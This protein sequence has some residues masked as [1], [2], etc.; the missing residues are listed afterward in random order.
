VRD[1][2]ER[3]ARLIARALKP[4]GVELSPTASSR[5]TDDVLVAH[6]EGRSPKQAATLQ[7]RAWAGS[8]APASRATT[9]WVLQKAS[10]DRLNM[11]R[12]RND[13]FVD[14]QRGIVRLALPWMIVD[15]SD[16]EIPVRRASSERALRDPFGDRASLVT[17]LLVEQPERR[18]GAREL[19][20]AA[21]VSTMTASH[22]I[23]QLR[24]LG[25]IEVQQRGRAFEARLTD[26]RRLVDQWTMRYDWR[27]S[28]S[29]T[30]QAPIGSPDRFLRRL[31]AALEGQR[32]AL[33]LQAGASLVAPHS[34]DETIHLY[35]DVPDVAHLRDVAAAAGWETG[36]GRLVLM[37]PWYAHSA[38]AG[39][40]SIHHLPVVSDLQLVLD[41]WHYP[42]R[43]REQAEVVLDL[44]DRRADTKRRVKR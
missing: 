32:W 27:R 21:G 35:V 44:M 41:L 31:P 43:G 25:A 20:E 7:L 11:L 1:H 13:N 12:A 19:A 18:W 37:R 34:I 10:P 33:T 30:V 9:V 23:R 16:V 26:L 17:R 14:V 3:A 2:L 38:W 28:Q 22:V 5:A 39:V 4:A 24:E 29:I 36:E 40:H 6:L 8:A 15:R 42:V